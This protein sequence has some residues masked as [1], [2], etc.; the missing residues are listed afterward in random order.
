[1]KVKISEIREGLEHILIDRGVAKDEAKILADEYLEGE[2]Q[3][4]HS[5]GL[6]AFPAIVEKLAEK[7][8]RSRVIK[9]TSSYLLLDANFQFGAVV[10]RRAA[11]WG[12]IASSKQGV[13]LVLIRNMTT[14]LR[15]ATV[16]KYVADKGYLGFVVNTGGMPMVAPP[17]G[18]DPVVGTNPIGIGIPTEKDPIVLD[19]ATSK[20]AWGE[21][22]LAK[23]FKH[24]LPKNSYYD[25]QGRMA[26]KPES[27]HSALAVG[28][29]KGF[30]LALFIEIVCGS[31]V[32]MVMGSEQLEGEYR[33]SPRGAFIL[34]INPRMSTKVSEFKK[35]NSKLVREIKASKK[36]RGVKEIVVPGERAMRKRK[37]NVRRGSLEIENKLWEEIRSLLE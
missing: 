15:P 2:L 27:A 25:K 14:W 30:G 19:M 37:K 9:E 12:I 33:I 7:R 1:M 17:G 16:A 18:Y 35:A 22:R 20:R 13:A 34:V 23:K 4:K 6:A 21:V 26:V 3:G 10:G 28:D 24:D 36:L 32:D 31:L 29:Y 8:K 11:D 5:H